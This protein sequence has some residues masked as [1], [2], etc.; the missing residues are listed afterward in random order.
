MNNV[1]KMN[2][3]IALKEFPEVLGIK[4]WEVKFPMPIVR[5]DRE[6]FVHSRTM[7]AIEWS[8]KILRLVVQLDVE[9]KREGALTELNQ[10]LQK[11]HDK[12]LN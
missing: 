12:F 3:D 8:M 2:D 9:L 1:I 7:S 6:H 4:A 10:C 5:E 11:I